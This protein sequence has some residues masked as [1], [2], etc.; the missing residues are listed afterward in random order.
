MP[1]M[2]ELPSGTITFLFTDI[3]G[4]TQLLKRFGGRYAALLATHRQLL[5]EAAAASGG[6][7]MGSE[8]DAMF[9]WFPRV[10]QAVTAAAESQRALTGHDWAEGEAIR[11]RMGLHTGEPEVVESEYVGMGLHHAARISN[12]AHGGQVLLSS[13]TAGVIADDSPPG[14]TVRC[15]GDFQLKDMDGPESLYQ[16]D[17]D[18]LPSEFPPLRAEL[19]EAP[20]RSWRAHRGLT[21]ILGVSLLAIAG[22]VTGLVLV[23]GGGKGGTVAGTHATVAPTTAPPTT[24]GTTPSRSKGLHVEQAW[25]RARFIPYPAKRKHEMAAYAKRH[26]GIDSWRI[27]GPHVIVEH[28]SVTPVLNA[29]IDAFASD[30]PDA[31]LGGLPGDCAHFVV[32]RDGSV[33]QLV[34]TTIMC[35]HTVGLNYTAIGIEHIGSSDADILDNARQRVASLRLTLWLMSRYRISLRNVIGHNES[36]RSPYHRERV[37]QWRCQTHG[38]WT[39]ADMLRYRRLLYQRGRSEGLRSLVPASEITGPTGTTPG[40]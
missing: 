36:L 6:S 23:S 12:A 28:Y 4:S 14:M 31:E 20:K 3:E 38:D 17:V 25:F 21:A 27:A 22:L 11:V 39:H 9:F 8:G 33:Y 26:Y 1:A 16:L 40:C 35:R 7:E 5:R 29:T 10:R 18:G 19:V 2:A 24:T 34:P 32:D 15:L 13:T 30:T 37:P